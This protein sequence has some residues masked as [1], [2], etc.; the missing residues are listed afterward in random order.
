MCP[1][2]CPPI[3]PKKNNCARVV[4][5]LDRDHSPILV[6]KDSFLNVTDATR[7]TGQE[8][9]NQSQ[10][11]GCETIAA[12]NHLVV[13]THSK[14]WQARERVGLRDC[15]AFPVVTHRVSALPDLLVTDAD[16]R[17]TPLDVESGLLARLFLLHVSVMYIEL[18]DSRQSSTFNFIP[19]TA[20]ESRHISSA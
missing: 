1:G 14:M 9:Q 5:E 7:V 19:F 16:Y 3:S 18:A 6:Q 4:S 12:T 2:T 10:A 8:T 13:G 11:I 17:H 15:T 20:H